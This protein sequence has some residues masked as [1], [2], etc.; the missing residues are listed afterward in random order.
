MLPTKTSLAIATFG[1]LFLA[2]QQTKL[3]RPYTPTAV[4]DFH[5]RQVHAVVEPPTPR[6]RERTKHATPLLTGP[7]LIDPHELLKPFYQAL[8]RTEAR[9]PGAVTRILH[10]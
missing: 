8:W 5:P 3:A 2:V 9:Q 10:Y 7:N 1:V 6:Q 4:V